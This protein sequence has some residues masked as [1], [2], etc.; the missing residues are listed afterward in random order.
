MTLPEFHSLDLL[1][2]WLKERPGDLP[3]LLD[4]HSEEGLLAAIGMIEHRPHLAQAYL[5]AVLDRDKSLDGAV[6][7]LSSAPLH[8]LGVGAIQQILER[9]VLREHARFGRA[10]GSATRTALMRRLNGANHSKQVLQLLVEHFGVAGRHDLE[11]GET[12]AVHLLVKHLHWRDILTGVAPRNMTETAKDLGREILDYLL[13]HGE[14]A[15][16]NDY[17]GRLLTSPLV[18]AC[19]HYTKE[20]LPTIGI[21]LLLEAGADYERIIHAINPEARKVIESHPIV[22]KKALTMVA[23]D[24]EATPPKPPKI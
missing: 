6:R 16:G 22:K 1:E 21:E 10:L 23:H 24:V 3:P 7:L 5:D 4:N 18:M 11:T 14:E 20:G 8:D 9:P 13:R 17:P 19:N 15:Y 2:T 12:T